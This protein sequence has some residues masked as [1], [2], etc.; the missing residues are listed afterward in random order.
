MIDSREAYT[1]TP[2]VSHAILAH[3]RG[4]AADDASR[5]DGVVVTPSH[6]PPRDGGFKY[7]PPD[8]GPAGA[9]I[10]GGSR[11]GPTS[12]CAAG[13][14]VRRTPITRA[15][16][17]DTTIGYDYL[18]ATSTTCRTSST[19]PPSAKPACASVPIRWA[20]RVLTTGARSPR[21][22]GST[23]P[24]STPTGRPAWR[25]MTLD[26]DG[27]IRMD[28]SSLR[29]W[30]RPDRQPHAVRHLDRQR[31]RRRPARH[32]HA[33]RRVDESQPL[34]AVAIQYL[35]SHRP[36]WPARRCDRQDPRLVRR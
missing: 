5:A 11:T 4:R 23:S 13:W 25:F 22:T 32:R 18:G 3:N 16:A 30:H 9:D 6:N 33:R 7:N 26:W 20:A 8:G 31:R 14:K 21:P 12:T 34:P 1:P 19:W 35:Y 29:R 10:T 24:S 36:H 27:K 2:A 28:C 17:A 15:R